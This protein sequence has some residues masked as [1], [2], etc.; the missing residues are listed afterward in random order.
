MSLDN[1]GD[2]FSRS[3]A[4]TFSRRS[5]LGKLGAGAVG[6][7]GGSMTAGF[8]AESAHAV[9][10]ACGCTNCGYSVQ[11]ESY[12]ASGSNCPSGSCKCGYWLQCAGCNGH[13]KRFQ[14]C[15]CGCSAGCHCRDGWPS[16]CYT[17]PY[18]SCN[19]CTRVKCRQ[20]F[21]TSTAC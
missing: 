19:G 11:C 20:I 5:F 13:Y 12:G 14:D 21:C 1:L 10:T 6:A 8:R 15:C 18:G 7:A 9:D 16:C 17:A 2:R 3:L 4:S